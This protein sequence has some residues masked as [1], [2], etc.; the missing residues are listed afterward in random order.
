[1][2]SGSKLHPLVLSLCLRW[3]GFLAVTEKEWQ[4]TSRAQE[5]PEK[6]RSFLPVGGIFFFFPLR[7]TLN[8]NKQ[9][10]G[11]IFFITPKNS[12]TLITPFHIHCEFCSKT[13]DWASLHSPLWYGLGCIILTV[14]LSQVNDSQ[15][16]LFSLP[17]TL[18]SLSTKAGIHYC[19]GV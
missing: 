9:H 11:H 7:R 2:K 12:P 16:E 5:C 1:M 4:T 14:Q 18:R 19:E 6:R 10:L 8:G 17:L 15:W 3:S 13:S